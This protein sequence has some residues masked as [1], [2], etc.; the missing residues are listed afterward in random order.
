MSRRDGR[1]L[2][3]ETDAEGNP[4][5]FSPPDGMP[6]QEVLSRLTHWREWIGVLDGEP[7]R[8]IWRVQTRCGVCEI[9]RLRQPV[10]KADEPVWLLYAWAD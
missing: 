7:E 6:R 5:A 4:T 8:D 10:A 1:L 2:R 9:H 3:V